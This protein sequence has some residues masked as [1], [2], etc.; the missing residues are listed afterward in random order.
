[1]RIAKAEAAAAGAEKTPVVE[2]VESVKAVYNDPKVTERTVVAL[3]QALGDAN[4][5]QNSPAMAAD[6]FAEYGRAGVPSFDF[7]VGAVNPRKQEAAHKAG[8][9]LPGLPP[10]YFPPDREPILKTGITAETAAAL[11]LLGKPK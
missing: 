7:W 11:E 9:E 4:V 10:A 3:K 6:D 2:V 1:G 8:K 5:V